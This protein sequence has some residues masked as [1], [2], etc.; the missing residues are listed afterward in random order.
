M[1]KKKRE[2]FYETLEKQD[3]KADKQASKILKWVLVVFATI[4]VVVSLSL[5]FLIFNGGIGSSE[6]TTVEIPEGS[7][8]SDI[9]AI[10]DDNDIIFND[11]L[12]VLY[13]RLTGN[14]GIQAGSYTLNTNQGF[15]DAYNQLQEGATSQ[16]DSI[17]IPEGSNLEGIS[18]IIAD[19]L[20]IEQEDAL[21]Q[22]TDDA[23]FNTLLETYPDLLT[24]VSENDEVRYKLEGYLYPATYEIA[25]TATVADIVTMM[26]DEMETVRQQHTEEI[27]ASGLT[28]HEFLTLASL[29]EGE[30]TSREDREM[31]AGVFLNRVEIDMPIQSDVSVLYA[32]NEHLAYVT[33]EDAAVDSPYNL[34]INT[35]FGPGPFN[36]PGIDSIEASMNPT[37]SEYLYFVA[38]LTTGEVYYSEDYEQ[39][40]AYVEEYVSEDNAD[41]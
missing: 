31:I 13:M 36:N 35:G 38:D 1:S 39:H 29:V 11:Y 15:D 14:D 16:A 27:E 33:N 6:E 2:E 23:L 40:E 34:Y 26:V 20:G 12:F 8:A 17:A 9:A 30:A 22:M 41:L 24:D 18:Q 25:P 37:D 19:A 32:N 7:T 5:S 3:Q 10:L 21:T 4:I 28:F